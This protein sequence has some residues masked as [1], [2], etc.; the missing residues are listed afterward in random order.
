MAPVSLPPGFRFH[1]SD[2]ELLSYYLKRKIH[3][4]KIELDIIP[5]VDLYKSEPWDL[6]NKSFLPNRD[7]EWYFF[8]PRDR[9]YPNGS[10][11]NRATEVGYWKATG[12]DRKINSHSVV[13][14]LKKTLVFYTGRAPQGKRT[15]WVMHEYRLDE[16]QCEGAAGLQDA[17]VL[18]RVFKKSAIEQKNA[19]QQGA[20]I[21]K[22][23]LSSSM[24]NSFSD[25]MASFD[26]VQRWAV[27]RSSHVREEKGDIQDNLAFPSETL[28]D[29][30]DCHD[31][32][33]WI[34][35]SEWDD[36]NQNCNFRF[37]T[38]FEND[39]MVNSTS[40]GARIQ[41]D[42][43]NP[44]LKTEDF[45][46]CLGVVDLNGS[47]VPV[48]KKANDPHEESDIIEEILKDAGASPVCDIYLEHSLSLDGS[49]GYSIR[50]SLLDNYVTCMGNNCEQFIVEELE[51]VLREE[52]EFEEC[53]QTSLWYKCQEILPSHIQTDLGDTGSAV[54]QREMVNFCGMQYK[55][56][57]PFT[58]SID[59][60][61][62]DGFF[63]ITELSL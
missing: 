48:T 23:V 18:C 39:L 4:R 58:S 12:K 3:G 46:G 50:E 7:L 17:F 49:A 1:P 9:K 62:M 33:N 13:L 16:M 54:L 42:S 59:Y 41:Q 57:Q 2:E 28:N 24:N 6:P 10:R 51:G 32:L 15:D 55:Y 30:M 40:Q 22:T 47:S 27:N 8:S 36:T 61:Q 35:E 29:R 45:T 21:E 38:N 26:D 25:K 52:A 5:E 43:A 14:G 53:P 60:S 56:S 19:E 63:S 34:L 20:E 31:A 44:L 11:T 37:P